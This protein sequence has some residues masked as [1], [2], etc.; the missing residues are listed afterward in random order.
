M[1]VQVL[2]DPFG[3]LLWAS[4]APPGSTHNLTA[5][6][7]HGTIDALTDA[8]AQVLGGQRLPRGRQAHPGP[9]PGPPAEAVEAPPQQQP[10]Q[11]PPPRRTG[12]GHPQGNVATA[13]SLG[14]KLRSAW[15]RLPDDG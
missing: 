8:G 5:A 4:L 6:R 2:T 13:C 15:R 7:T 9:V 10:H 1:N 12:R 14:A 3:R 11:D